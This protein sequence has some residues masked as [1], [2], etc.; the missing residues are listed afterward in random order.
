MTDV[1]DS[2]ASSTDV[3][4]VGA[5]PAGHAA[6]A[7]CA[8]QGL[9]VT[10]LA[11][12][13]TADWSQTYGAWH[14]E[15]EAVGLTEVI[16]RRWSDTWVRTGATPRHALD[17]TYC[18]IDNARLR[19]RL[20][21]TAHAAGA[22][23][24]VGRAVAVERDRGRAVIATA[25]GA[26]YGARVVVDATGH[27]SALRR[28]RRQGLAYQTAYGVVASFDR[29]PIPEGSMCLMDF[30]A[31]AFDDPE[32]PT[33]L[34]AM[35]L[36][37][38]QFLVE[39][40][41]LAR[42]P[43]LPLGLLAQR[44]RRRLEAR[45]CPPRDVRST[46]QVAF[47]M[48]APLPDGGRCGVTSFGAAG[49]LV[50]PATGY[51]V[52]TALRRAPALAAALRTAL[53]TPGATPERAAAA[54]TAAVWPPTLRRRHALYRIGLEV[55]LRLDVNATQRFFDAFFSLPPAAWRGY[56]SWTSP[57]VELEATML[58]LM[59][60]LPAQDRA[61]VLRAAAGPPALRWALTATTG[62]PRLRASRDV[63]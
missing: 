42:R 43:G 21:Q 2:G 55:L 15:L 31:T 51:Q 26:R 38:D 46:E 14:D 44:L 37:D 50:H 47:A 63:R 13:P 58:R 16:G 32:P 56:V 36:G 5:G 25:D 30:D 59:V 27:P 1:K 45:G 20:W 39:E 54:G 6:A 53:D 10:L 62:W 19:A 41:C 33:F 23:Q 49:G 12:D 34:Y 18:L 7:A 3:L 8:Q 61:D 24:V 57:P 17:R 22:T 35:D 60:G 28:D 52:A 9:Q 48:D 40:T 11:I 4:V 29:P